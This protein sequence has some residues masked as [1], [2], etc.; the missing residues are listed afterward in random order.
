M[1]AVPKLCVFTTSFFD[2]PRRLSGPVYG[3]IPALGSKDS[4]KFEFCR[5]QRYNV[6]KDEVRH[7]IRCIPQVDRRMLARHQGI[8]DAIETATPIIS[9]FV[10]LSH[11]VAPYR[12]QVMKPIQYRCILVIELRPLRQRLS[13]DTLVY[14]SMQRAHREADRGRPFTM[15]AG[16]GIEQ[17]LRLVFGDHGSTVIDNGIGEMTDKCCH[18]HDH[19]RSSGPVC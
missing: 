19:R 7:R 13:G 18:R 6:T 2:T 9:S 17:K 14:K 3:N 15:S 4:Q 16:N 5:W 8:H 10:D 1:D 12:M 11:V